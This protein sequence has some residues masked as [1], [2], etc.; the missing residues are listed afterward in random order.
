MVRRNRHLGRRAVA[1]RTVS[2]RYV[3]HD[4]E[5]PHAPHREGPPRH[6]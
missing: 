5:P 2:P 4:T 1:V 6:H 3:G